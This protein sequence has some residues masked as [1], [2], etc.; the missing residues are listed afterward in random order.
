MNDLRYALRQVFTRPA[1]SV[2]VVLMLALGI[3]ATTAIYSMF[4]QVLV[5]PLPVP[6]PDRL[7]NL[8][9]P[10]PKWGSTSCSN[11]GGCDLVFSYPM[12]RDLEAQQQPFTGIAAHRSFSANIAA[13]GETVSASGTL[14]SGEYFSVLRLAPA[15]GR[16]IGPHDE[17]QVG[18]SAVVVLSHEYWQ[19]GFG[20]DPGVVGRRLVVNGQTLEI[21]GVAPEGFTGTTLGVRPNIFVPLTLRWLMQP[22]VSDDSEGRTSY[23]LYVF[24]RLK[25]GMT[26]EQA[27]ASID[28]LYRGILAE[29]ERPLNDSMPEDVM[30]RFLER[31]VAMEPGESGQSS[32]PEDAAQPMTILLSLTGLVLL[33]VCV[34][35]ANLLLARGASRAG[36][37]AIRASIGASRRRLVSQLLTES[38]VLAALGG[39]VSIPVALATIKIIT[40][41]MPDGMALTLGFGLSPAALTFAAAVIL[42]TVLL[43]GLAPAL[44]VTRS[45]PGAVMKGHS[46]KSMGGHGMTRFRGVLA[47]VQIAF[48]MVLLVLAGLFTQSLVN[49][50]RVDLGMQVD[51]VVAFGVAPRLNGYEP[52]HVMQL[53]DRIEEELAAQPGVT[54]VSSSMVAVLSSSNW[55]NSLTVEG[56]EVGPTT[57]TIAS[58]NEISPDFL[59]TFSIPL[60]AGRA[61]TDQDTLG[62]PNVA[63][64]NEAFLRK[65]D[66]GASETIGKRIG[67]GQGDS[68]QLDTEIVGV[69]ADAK[70]SEVKDDVPAQYFKPRK[71]NDNLGSLAFYVRAGIEP[72]A[73][74]GTIRRVVGQIDPNLPVAGLITMRRAAADN[75]FLDRM[76][77]ILSAGFAALATLLAAI[78]LYGVLAYNVTQRTREFGLRMALGAAPAR[79]RAMVLR[80]VG[81]MAV[82]GGAV[83]LGA[84]LGLGRLAEALLFGLTG[85]DPLVIGIAL[86]LLAAV[87]LSAGYLPARRASKVAPMEALREE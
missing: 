56:F 54:S 51:S 14:V 49:I 87:V 69:V 32:I 63:I 2:V 77:A 50:T 64:V 29:V 10:G 19:N 8:A 70:Y 46:S 35:V 84:A 30:A 85:Y 40:A 16:L 21:V 24:A 13:E 43:F 9:S 36:E 7:V 11:S 5:R 59:E 38:A 72:E 86:V 83:G 71:Q 25:P 17:P 47:T 81:L 4:H 41:V 42:G 67:L 15:L 68:V 75:V 62:T 12:F 18:E 37:I 55:N 48:S 45:D 31:E 6:E 3:G 27:K 66:L 44:Q 80:Q 60:L 78:G 82:V 53:Y 26:I 79:L 23:W 58:L 39:L 52:E 33:I 1:L 61:F 34:N 57:D 76:M 74:M 73:V 20:G 22:T 65:F 28:V